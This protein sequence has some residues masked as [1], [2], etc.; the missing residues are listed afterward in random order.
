MRYLII[1]FIL[2]F[3]FSPRVSCSQDLVDHNLKLLSRLDYSREVSDIWGY[4]DENGREYAIMGIET[5]TV[6]IDVSDPFNPEEIG[7][8]PGDRSKWRDFKT[9]GTYAYGVAEKG[10]DG[11]LIIDLSDLPDNLEYSYANLTTMVN[12]TPD[13]LVSAH[14]IFID[15]NGWAYLSG[16]N[17]NNGGIVAIDVSS[18]PINPTI[19]GYGDSRYSHDNFA[20][21]DTIWS[22]DVYRGFFSVLDASD[23]SNI[24][25]LITEQTSFRFTHNCWL[26]DDGDYLFTTDEKEKAFIDVYDVS[27]IMDIQ[28]IARFRTF[29][30]DSRDVAPHNVYYF[31]D[32]LLI[33]YYGDG[34]IIVDVSNPEFPI[35]VGSYDTYPN[36]SEGLWGCWGVYPYLPSGNIIASDILRGLFVLQPDYKR[37]SFLEGLITNEETGLPVIEAKVEILDTIPNAYY[38]ENSG[39]YKAGAIGSKE[40]TFIVSHPLYNPD[41]LTI[42]LTEGIITE[43]DIALEPIYTSH[44]LFGRVIDL[45]TGQPV[46]NSQVQFRMGVEEY[47]FIT[48]VDGRFASVMFESDY[49][50]EYSK[51]G[52]LDS[53]Y[54]FTGFTMN[55]DIELYLQSGYLDRFFTDQGWQVER[56]ANTGN[57]VRAVPIGTFEGD[58]IINPNTDSPWDEDDFCYVTGNSIGNFSADDIDGG[59][60]WLTS[61]VMTLNS[62]GDPRLSFDYWYFNGF[63]ES[64]PNDTLF[65]ELLDNTNRTT[66]LLMKIDSSVQSWQQVLDIPLRLDSVDL[67]DVQIRFRVGDEGDLWHIIEAAIDRFR[68]IDAEMLT[69]VDDVLDQTGKFSVF[70]NPTTDFIQLNSNDPIETTFDWVEIFDSSGRLLIRSGSESIIDVRNINAGLY[71][72]RVGNDSGENTA[73]SR[74]VKIDH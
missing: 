20:R 4:A 15:E 68:V 71:T 49:D 25:T 74:F 37:A 26:S 13:T 34:V 28:E 9:Y 41:T 73:T 6:I 57:W 19:K 44:T 24:F 54:Q 42:E 50:I 60:T 33:S 43:Q 58:S 36:N 27:D 12:G 17:I 55:A 1:P 51:W 66:H 72:I 48:G 11:L 61:P 10:D 64:P 47:D 46:D 22:A 32:Y 67:S 53:I 8:I 59:Y 30:A 63:G 39:R 38:S 56:K 70:P 16:A 3:L 69:S 5:G 14:N 18:D 52:Y 7:F 2:S 40:I 31:N 29:E 65:V 23:K 45:A 62:Y 21:G 35:Q